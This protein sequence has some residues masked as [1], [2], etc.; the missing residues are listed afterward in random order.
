MSPFASRFRWC[1][2]CALLALYARPVSADLVKLKSGGELRGVFVD[3]VVTAPGRGSNV[4]VRV[5]TL[6]GG[7]ITVSHEDVAFLAKRNRNLEEYEWRSRL[8]PQTV[9]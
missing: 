3:K 7:I 4:P 5:E 1:C 6:T 8:A 9:A 2:L